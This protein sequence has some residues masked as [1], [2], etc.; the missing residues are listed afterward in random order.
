MIKSNILKTVPYPDEFTEEDKTEYDQL[1]AQAKLI[2]PEV[3]KEN[4][5]IIYISI[6]AHIRAK[7]GM[8]AEFTDEE[9]IAVKNSYKLASKV[10][11]CDAPE[12]HYIYDKE[13]NPMYFPATVT[14]SSDDD[15][16]PNIILDSEGAKCQ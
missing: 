7:K 8:A 6:I 12:D 10:I 4:P 13:N 16:K 5:Y 1:Y 3:E 2:H 9:L 14:I 11:E 15:K